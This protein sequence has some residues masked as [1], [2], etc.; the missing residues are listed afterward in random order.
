MPTVR[1][2]LY[3]APWANRPSLI[4]AI[5]GGEKQHVKSRRRPSEKII[6]LPPEMLEQ[7]HTICN[8]YMSSE[9]P[10]SAWYKAWL[11][12]IRI[13]EPNSHSAIK[14]DSPDSGHPPP[15]H[16]QHF[17]SIIPWPRKGISEDKLMENENTQAW[18]TD[19]SAQYMDASHYSLIQRRSY[20]LAEFETVHLVTYWLW[21]KKFSEIRT[22]DKRSLQRLGLTG[23][24]TSWSKS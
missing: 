6:A 24:L 8:R 13:Y 17:L 5:S 14:S 16:W 21:Q 15:L 10:F 2:K 22:L 18:F 12:D 1:S 11:W 3:L 19:G 4:K 9:M 23:S 20:Q 7:G